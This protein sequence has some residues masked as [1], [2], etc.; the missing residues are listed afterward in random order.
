[1]AQ[2]H[3]FYQKLEILGIQNENKKLD[4]KIH[5]ARNRHFVIDKES[6]IMSSNTIL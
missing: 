2:S 3:K 4:Q 1:M 6:I 5:V